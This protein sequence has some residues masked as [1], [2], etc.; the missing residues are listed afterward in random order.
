MIYV[1]NAVLLFFFLIG[2][3][4]DF[5]GRN[6]NVFPI[7][8]FISAYY[9]VFFGFFPLYAAWFVPHP[10]YPVAVSAKTT[11]YI[12]LFAA[13]QLGGYA[14]WLR[15]RVPWPASAATTSHRHLPALTAL[16]FGTIMAHLLFVPFPELARLPSLPQLREPLWDFGFAVLAWLA[17]A[18]RL[19]GKLIAA[20][21]ALAAAKTLLD[22]SGGLITQP[23]FSFLILGV[24]AVVQRKWRIV[25]T[26][27]AASALILASYGY[28]KYL[29]RTLIRNGPVNIFQFEPE[30]SFKAV[31]ASLNALARRSAH[32]FVVERVIEATPA[33]VPYSDHD[34][35][36]R[37]VLNHV[38][39]ILWPGKPRE[40]MGNAFGKRYGLVGAGD[41][42]TSWNVPWAADFYMAYGFFAALPGAFVV[43]AMLAAA[44]GWMSARSDR[45][46]WFGVYGATLF[47][48]FYQESN[49]SLMTG[50]VLWTAAFLTAAY[51][52][53][54][55][56]ASAFAAGRRTA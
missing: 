40:E 26:V 6:R 16:A 11:A 10:P 21:L 15:F 36:G 28:V 32:A 34:P 50:S 13:A 4:I 24:A 37:A 49:F 7:A 22:L 39:R 54:R 1:L 17:L 23:L 20:W 52:T 5:G 46:F 33:T 8:S 47:P 12:V 25:A 2:L 18:R 29:H 45:V 14:A 30:L 27:L 48:L 41:D 42:V 9:L 51:G 55:M 38:P 31:K 43:G 19:S 44:V 35:L 56:L 3:K 53:A